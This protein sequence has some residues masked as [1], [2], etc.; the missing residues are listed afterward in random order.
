VVGLLE[1]CQQHVAAELSDTAPNNIDLAS[2]SGEMLFHSF[3]LFVVMCSLIKYLE[4]NS[5]FY[6]LVL[7]V[8]ASLGPVARFILTIFPFYMAFI[9][10]VSSLVF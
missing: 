2:I 8:K 10:V 7:A 4:F 6:M 9:L 1:M 5:G 3:G